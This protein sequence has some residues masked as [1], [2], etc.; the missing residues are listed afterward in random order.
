MGRRGWIVA[1]MAFMVVLYCNPG[2][3]QLY[4]TKSIRLI[5]MAAPGGGA[6]ALARNIGQKL[7]E[8]LGQ[9]VVVDNRGAG[10]GGMETV[11]HAAPDGYTLLL[12]GTSNLGIAPSLYAKLP[13]DPVKDYV[14]IT[15]LASTP[16]ILVVHPSV[17]AKSLKEFVAYVKANPNK[18][19]YASPNV[20]SN[21]HL[22]GGLLNEAAGIDMQHVPY[23]GAAQA[24]VD[25]LAGRVPVMISAMSAVV[26]HVKS[27]KLRALAV[28]GAQRVSAVPEV[29]TIAESGYPGFEASTWF[30][31]LAPAGTPKP[32]VTRL[33]NEIVRILNIPDVRARLYDIGGFEFIGSTPEAFGSYIKT[34]IK[35]WE[36]VVKASGATAE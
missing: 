5:V 34:E 32:I 23:K 10:L 30:G 7:S 36:K 9:P 11:A 18:I 35:K 4:P 6:D 26:P 16:N 15:Q 20:G 29:P 31:V 19:N 33:N 22:S 25:V 28:T 27:G 24:V 21:G 14:P 2:L 12:C 17:P 1:A 13:Y 3:A 8:A